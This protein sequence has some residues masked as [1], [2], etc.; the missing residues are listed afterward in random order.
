L[1]STTK[2][3]LPPDDRVFLP[4]GMAASAQYG[5]IRSASSRLQQ[6]REA[7]AHVWDCNS[8]SLQELRL[9]AKSCF[10]VSFSHTPRAEGKVCVRL[11]CSAAPLCKAGVQYE[12]L[13]CCAAAGLTR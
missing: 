10:N 5:S 12:Q 6:A 8:F 1:H 2:M 13:L 11:P 7:A 4:N 3:D 9:A